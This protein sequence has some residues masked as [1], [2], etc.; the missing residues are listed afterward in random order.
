[1]PKQA[2]QSRA[3][4]S[5][6]GVGS[7]NRRPSQTSFARCR[8]ARQSRAPF[9]RSRPCSLAVPK[10]S[11]SRRVGARA[12]APPAG[13]LSLG[14]KKIPCKARDDVYR[15]TTLFRSFCSALTVC[16]VSATRAPD[17]PLSLFTGRLP[18]WS[19]RGSHGKC[20]QP[21]TLSL[22]SLP[23]AYSHAFHAW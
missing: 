13:L 1:M 7:L 4:A 14:R 10:A 23:P 2:R 11:L 9:G 20:F 5:F 18:H 12:P 3:P 16:I 19:F 21:T 17:L 15:G 22:C 8:V 6:P